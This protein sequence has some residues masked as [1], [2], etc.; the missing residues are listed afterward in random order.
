MC[1]LMLVLSPIVGFLTG[2]FIYRYMLTWPQV[3]LF[4]AVTPFIVLGILSTPS[5]YPEIEEWRVIYFWGLITFLLT[6]TV[7]ERIEKNKN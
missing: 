5:L 6:Y 3:F 1:V 7:K 2:I 4:L